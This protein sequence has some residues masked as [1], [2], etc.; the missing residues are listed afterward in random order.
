MGPLT[1]DLLLPKHPLVKRSTK[2]Q[3]YSGT[4]IRMA[5][6]DESEQQGKFSREGGDEVDRD[7]SLQYW[8][9]TANVSVSMRGH[10]AGKCTAAWRSA[11][12]MV[13]KVS[14]KGS[15]RNGGE[16]EPLTFLMSANAFVSMKAIRRAS[17]EAMEEFVEQ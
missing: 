2:G 9:M 5:N 17:M 7:H 4:A 3:V 11:R 1:T 10:Q 14:S 15:Y 12:S 8:S 16:A 13:T 6:V